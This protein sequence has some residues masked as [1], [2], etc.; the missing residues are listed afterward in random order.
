LPS[1]RHWGRIERAV[2]VCCVLSV[3]VAGYFWIG[4]NT[5]AARA[6]SLWTALDRR[7]PFV[8]EAI[9][10]YAWMYTAMVF[11]LFSVR[12][13]ALFR[14][15]A[16]AYAVT[17][18]IS[19]AVFLV[20]PVS[21]VELRQSAGPVDP[22]RFSG[23]GI[24]TLYAL[25]PPYNLFP[26]IHL[27]IAT[28]AA[29]AAGTARRSYGVIG[30]PCVVLIAASVSL[31]KQHYLADVAAGVALAVAVH[32]V[33]IRPHRPA[34]AEEPAYGWLGPAAYLAFHAAVYAAAYA[35]FRMAIDPA[36]RALAAAGSAG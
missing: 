12:S 13:R 25:D 9:F 10:L 17:I 6:H 36:A 18:A 24:R 8:P 30:A 28:L 4:W 7:V 1:K 16:L 14:R 26:S 3:Y 22:A 33:F 21:G 15:V 31:V 23:W 19:F 5:P 29:L 11:P 27:S 20:Y 2:I 34:A 32:G 35:A